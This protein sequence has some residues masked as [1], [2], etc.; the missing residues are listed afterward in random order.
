VFLQESKIRVA[1]ITHRG[2]K[3]S[4]K[5]HDDD[6]DDDGDADVDADDDA[7]DDMMTTMIMMMMMSSILNFTLE[8]HKSKRNDL[9]CQ[10]SQLAHP[11]TQPTRTPSQPAQ[12][13]SVSYQANWRKT[14]GVQTYRARSFLY[15]F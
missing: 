9:T 3:W 7:D 4:L 12:G 2:C 15:A 8:Q 5:R 1:V 10:A 14:G 6:A 11:Q 13:E